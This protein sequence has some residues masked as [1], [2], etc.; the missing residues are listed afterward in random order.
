MPDTCQLPIDTSLNCHPV[1]IPHYLMQAYTAFGPTLIQP[2]WFC[3]RRLFEQVGL[4]SEDGKVRPDWCAVCP[5]CRKHLVLWFVCIQ[6]FRMLLCVCTSLQ[7]VVV[8]V[9]I[10]FQS[11]VVCMYTNLKNVLVYVYTSLQSVVVCVCTSLQWVVF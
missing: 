1:I 3:S 11:V 7:S 10:S 8:Y 9:Y 6:V 2:T 4:F 5:A